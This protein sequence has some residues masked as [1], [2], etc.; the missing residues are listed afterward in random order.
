V[1]L[2]ALAGCGGAAHAPP[3]G[4]AAR[5]PPGSVADY[6]QRIARMQNELDALVQ[7]ALVRPSGQTLMEEDSAPL[8]QPAGPPVPDCR[9]AADL[10]D[11]ICE[12]AERICAISERDPA[13]ADLQAKC[14]SAR[15]ACDRAREDVAASCTDE[16]T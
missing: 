2:I 6:E 9:A 15:G 8:D 12:L 5:E 13:D 11:R 16:D 3:T 14:T 7:G 4:S 1:L 10:R